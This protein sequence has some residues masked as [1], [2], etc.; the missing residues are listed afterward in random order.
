MGTPKKARKK[1]AKKPKKTSR[2]TLLATWSK[3]VRERDANVCVVCGQA[4]HLQ[5][6]H[7]LPKERYSEHQFELINGV[8]LCPTH[9]KFGKLSF[10]RN[11][12]WSVL[13]LQEHRPVQFEWT[14][15]NIA[16]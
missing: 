13:W 15:Q 14:K 1:K 5:A 9:H 10:H 2:R 7:L 11:P 16:A 6:H 12:I 4:E 8:S 3:S